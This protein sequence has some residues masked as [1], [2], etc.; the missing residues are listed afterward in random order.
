[1]AS[2]QNQTI[3]TEA[4]VDDY[5]SGIEDAHRRK[6]CLRIDAIMRKVT[7]REPVM[8]GSSIVGYGSY[9]YHYASGREGD[10]L[11]TGFSSRKQNITIYIMDGFDGRDDLLDGLGGPHKTAKSCLYLRDF[12]KI[13]AKAFTRLVRKSVADMRKR[14]RCQ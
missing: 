10:W 2:N 6:Q 5:L 1:M 3:P 9:H 14:Y 7:R 12:D 11:L 13:D 8:W 4:S